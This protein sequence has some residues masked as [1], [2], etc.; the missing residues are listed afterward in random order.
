MPEHRTKTYLT[1]F[2]KSAFE[3]ITPER[4]GFTDEFEL[5]VQSEEKNSITIRIKDP[6]DDGAPRYYQIS[7]KEKL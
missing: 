2:V 4:L 6:T 5:S 3:G 1:R 7:V